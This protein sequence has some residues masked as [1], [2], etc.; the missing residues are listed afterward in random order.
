MVLPGKAK[1]KSHL[2]KLI[3][4]KP[5][6]LKCSAAAGIKIMPIIAFGDFFSFL[7][8]GKEMKEFLSVPS[9]EPSP[10]QKANYLTARWL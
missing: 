10:H 7:K 4:Q 2:D 1:S 5:H 3:W 8:D 9:P 6:L